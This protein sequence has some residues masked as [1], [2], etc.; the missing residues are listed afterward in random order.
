MAKEVITRFKL[1]TTAFDSAIKKA[2]KD[3][4]DYSKTATQAKEGFNQFTKSEVDAARAIGTMATSSTNAKGK[5][6]ELVGSY[7]ELVK[8]YSRLT[9]EQKQSDFAKA[10]ADSMTTLQQRIKD[11]KQELYGLGEEMKKT[12][13][14]GIFSGDKLSGMLQVFGGNLMTKGAGMLAGLADEMGDMAF[15]CKQLNYALSCQYYL[16][17]KTFC[18]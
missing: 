11:A 16:T 3:L 12:G 7:N 2:S 10:M 5:V 15:Y 8:T 6:Q 14:N 1:E 9:D 4:S 13:G 17:Q 18:C